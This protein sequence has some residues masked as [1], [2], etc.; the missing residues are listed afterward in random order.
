MNKRVRVKVCG[1]KTIK[2][3][4]NSV[5][6][7]CD[8]LGLNFYPHSVRC[9]TINTALAIANSLPP[10]VSLV[11][12]FA[13]ANAHDVQEVFNNIK[14]IDYFQFHGNYPELSI[15]KSKKW[16]ATLSID[17]S[18]P[19]DLLQNKLDEF[20]QLAIPPCSILIDSK[21]KGMFGGTGITAPWKIIS[22][23]KCNFPL[24]LAGGLTP[25][26]VN[27]AILVVKPYGVDVAS[28]VESEPGEKSATKLKKFISNSFLVL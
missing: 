6:A 2:D 12:V 10:F 24:L 5:E 3:A 21:I 20:N 27:E 14:R 16:I 13:N 19:L 1:V 9:I 28:G 8:A 15:I 7:G 11:A 22:E 26:N 4:L 25:E 17:E 18:M 23:L